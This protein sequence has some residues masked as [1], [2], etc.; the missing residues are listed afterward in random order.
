MTYGNIATFRIVSSSRLLSERN[1]D[2]V[3]RFKIDPLDSVS[4]AAGA[5]FAGPASETAV[6]MGLGCGV[7]VLSSLNG[8]PIVSPWIRTVSSPSSISIGP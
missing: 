3:V 6:G 4:G 8:L 5:G 2:E 1:T 7:R